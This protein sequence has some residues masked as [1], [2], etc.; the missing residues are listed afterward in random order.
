MQLTCQYDASPPASE[1]LWKKDGTVIA[2]NASTVNNDSRVTIPHYNESQVQLS[3]TATTSQ[4]SGNYTCLVINDV[5]N[6]TDTAIIV[7]EGA[8]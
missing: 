3:I 6:S 8:F 7:I 1:V 5:G 2:R 4:D